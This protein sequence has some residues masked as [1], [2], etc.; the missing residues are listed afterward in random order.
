MDPDAAEMGRALAELSTMP[1]VSDPPDASAPYEERA[2]WSEEYVSWFIDHAPQ[3][4]P[5]PK[6]A[7]PTHRYEV[8]FDCSVDDPET[9]LRDTQHELAHVFH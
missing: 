9:Y 2:A 8:E 5:E 3:D 6:D 7:R 4:G 1:P